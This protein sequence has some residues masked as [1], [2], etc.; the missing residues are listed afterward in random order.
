MAKTREYVLPGA[1][2]GTLIYRG[3]QRDQPIRL[4][5]TQFNQEMFV[6]QEDA[7]FSTLPAVFEDE[8]V[9][10]WILVEGVH[11]ADL[12]S[13]ICS[14]LGINILITEDVLNPRQRPKM[15]VIDEMLFV[16]LRWVSRDEDDYVETEN[17]YL[18]MSKRFV[19]LFREN[20]G[21]EFKPIFERLSRKQSRLRKYAPDY[22]AY[23]LID[24][25]ADQGLSVV[26]S[27]REEIEDLEELILEEEI[28]DLNRLKHFIRSTTHLGRYMRQNREVLQ[29]I[30]SF[31]DA[32][33][34][35]VTR[36][37]YADAVDHAQQASETAEFQRE[38]LKGLMDFHISLVGQRTNE[39]MKFLTLVGTIF[40]PLTFIV[41]VYGM[42][43]QNMPELEWE[44]GYPAVIGVMVLTAVGLL[45]YFRRRKWL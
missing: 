10:H 25:V 38:V 19:V 2:P 12:I 36:K 22:L 7:R 17:L 43:F 44:Y 28:E 32:L 23:A 29:N 16:V 15:E 35:K 21:D 8:H 14:N 13:T 4:T 27:V 24:L 41:G 6:V 30:Q 3:E 40:I 45:W 5:W 31:P 26:N 18:V 34:S 11:D 1:P 33:F 39:I 20:T 42:N 9:F 37:F